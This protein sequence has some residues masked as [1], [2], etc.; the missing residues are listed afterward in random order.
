MNE[1]DLYMSIVMPA[2][3]EEGNILAAVENALGALKDYDL[4]GEIIVVNDGST[5]KT[6][7]LVMEKIKN[8][9]NDRI[10]FI[11]HDK[12]K[13]IGESFWDGVSQSEGEVVTMFPGDNENDPWE[14]MRY[15]GLLEHVDMV[16][17]FVFNKDVRSLFRNI[18]SFAYR[19]IINTT[20]RVNFHYTNGTILYRKSI[21][22]KIKHRS[23][24][25][26]FQTEILIKMAKRGYL[27][28]EVPYRLGMR[29][30]GVSKAVSFPSFL[31]VM[32]GYYRLIND[33]YFSKI[34]KITKGRF[35]KTSKSAKRYESNGR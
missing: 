27:F 7:G 14:V 16:I 9:P 35:S 11:N 3:D 8:S 6:A 4:R 13:G 20:F 23:K 30:G 25:F 33:I 1:P 17:P 5:D 2:L 31:Q 32:R 28:A 12:P 19:F 34:T 15:V 22:S 26:F 10:K 21:L 18:L 29:P 24:G